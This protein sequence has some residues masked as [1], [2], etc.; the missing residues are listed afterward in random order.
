[1]PFRLEQ[2]IAR[3]EAKLE[4]RTSQ[5]DS[6]LIA[7]QS[8]SCIV[9]RAAT[10]RDS[11]SPPRLPSAFI[12]P[13][14]RTE[15]ANPQP[16]RPHA[17]RVG[18]ESPRFSETVTESS[19]LAAATPPS[20]IPSDPPTTPAAP[21]CSWPA[22]QPPPSRSTLRSRSSRPML[23]RQKARS[24]ARGWMPGRLR[25]QRRLQPA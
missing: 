5:L 11:K 3:V 23:P 15:R 17:G 13:L 6:K 18:S 24:P 19:R 8:S 12:R 10:V 2:R 22:R 21:G 16:L 4:Q 20:T 1:M 9:L 25:A 14:P 7:V